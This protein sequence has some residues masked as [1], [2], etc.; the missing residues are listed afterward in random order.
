MVST[1]R[2]RDGQLDHS[3]SGT[4]TPTVSS[5]VHAVVLRG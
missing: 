3:R 1:E 4:D 2:L 5:L